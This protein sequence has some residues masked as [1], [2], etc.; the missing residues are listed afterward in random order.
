LAFTLVRQHGT[1]QEMKRGQANER[2]DPGSEA[3][4]DDDLLLLAVT[5]VKASAVD[6]QRSVTDVAVLFETLK[7]LRL[8]AQ[9][10]RRSTG[11]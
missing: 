9:S 1:R 8:P 6:D 3:L 11:S 10:Q 5:L 7:Q 2:S 4:S